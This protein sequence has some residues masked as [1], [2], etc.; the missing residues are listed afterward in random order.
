M[1]TAFDRYDFASSDKWREIENNLYFTSNSPQEREKILLKR[2]RKSVPAN[3]SGLESCGGIAG[4][5]QFADPRNLCYVRRFFKANIDPNF[6]WQEDEGKPAAAAAS[7]SSASSQSYSSSTQQPS[8]QP[9]Q[10][11]SVPPSSPR[12]SGASTK[13]PYSVYLSYA[14]LALHV[15]IILNVVTFLLPLLGLDQSAPSFWRVMV[16]NLVAQ[17]IYLYRQHGRPRWEASYGQRLMQDEQAHFMFLSI[18]LMNAAPS[19]LLVAPFL[20]RSTLFVCGGLKQLLPARAPRIYS[21]LSRPIESVVARYADL[22][23]T[24]AMLE[25]LGGFMLVFQLFTSNRN[26]MLLFGYGQYLRIRAML[27]PNSKLAW[28][29]V[30]SK[31]DMWVAAPMVPAIVRTLYFKIQGFMESMVDQEALQQQANQP[32]LMSKC[33]IM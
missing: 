16:L 20:V 27:D 25:V 28:S 18:V 17:A 31:T 33:T 6:E 22:Y 21:L 14:Q 9:Q 19:M 5:C 3:A 2:K 11:S 1:S 7:N 23:R 12:S 10:S 26:I 32:G 24:N 15:L 8:P 29:Q 4:P 30:R 13:S